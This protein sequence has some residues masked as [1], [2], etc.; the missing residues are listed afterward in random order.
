MTGM[1]GITR[2]T[3]FWYIFAYWVAVQH[4]C[5]GNFTINNYLILT[6]VAGGFG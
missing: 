2:V 6:G 3:V 4:I 1:T 5:L